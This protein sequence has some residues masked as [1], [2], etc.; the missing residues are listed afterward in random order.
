MQL[1]ESYSPQLN[2]YIVPANKP[3]TGRARSLLIDSKLNV[4]FDETKTIVSNDT[5]D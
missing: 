4:N 2:S 1:I 3:L 5:A